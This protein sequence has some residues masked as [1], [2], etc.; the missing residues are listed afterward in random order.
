M[1]RY[2]KQHDFYVAIVTL[3]ANT[4]LI[5]A[6]HA[7]PVAGTAIQP[8]EILVF[9]SNFNL[10]GTPVSAS[11]GVVF[12]QQL[13]LRPISRTAELLEFVPGLIATQHSGEGKAN[14]YFVRGFNLDHGTDFAIRLDR[15][16]VNMPSHGH[17]Q[18]Y[19]DINFIIPELVNRMTYRKGPYYASGGDF[20]TAGE[21]QFSY[22]DKLEQGQTH[23]TLGENAFQRF[24]AGQSL[25]IGGGALTLA[26]A[27]SQYNGPWQLDQDL[28]KRKLVAKFHQSVDSGAWSITAMHYN[29]D[30]T[31]TDQIPLRAVESG[32]L[33]RWG[34]IDPTAG[35]DSRRNSL[36]FDLQQ[37]LSD[38]TDWRFNA[39]GID[40]A[41]DLYSNFTYFANNPVNGDQFQQTD[42]RRIAGFDSEYRRELN[43][44]IPTEIRAG[45][46]H[47]YDDIHVGLHLTQAR[48]RYDSVRND[49]VEQ[50]LSSSYV[51]A[52]QQWS[53]RI[54]TESSLR[55][56]HYRFEVSDLLGR[57]SGR[58][59][60]TLFSPKFNLVYAPTAGVETFFSAG[61]GFHSNDARGATI[62]VDPVTGLA[63][64]PVDPMAD[65]RSVELGLR[66]SVIPKTQLA[67]T[68]FSMRLSSEL[69]Y[70]GDAGSTEASDASQREGLEINAIYT[71]NSWLL[72]DADASVT[73]ARIRGVGAENRIPN[74][75]RN[76]A[77]LGM[78]IDDLNNWSGG[79]RVRYLG[80]AP[81]IE[82]ASVFSQSTLLMN[83]E[84]S[85]AFTP[86]LSVAVSLLNLLDSD[87]ND[88]TYFYE[89]QLAKESAPVEDIHFHPVEPRSVRVS[90]NAR[91]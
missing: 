66:T 46:Q 76:T 74:A 84:L 50:S 1:M 19:A 70:V 89:S 33:S 56:D 40:Y 24:F 58:G 12:E 10:R 17:G 22:A 57:N 4:V 31:S 86:T 83:A 65:A 78:I 11:E 88:I 61:R 28:D 49:D 39:Y 54:R 45:V 72:F 68:A 21:A 30:W 52:E 9:G 64:D 44:S 41:L 27:L 75:V 73:N 62:Q 20:A 82:D 48:Q 60:D 87:D 38:R 42:S 15:M 67:V 13:Q 6:V 14:Q 63:T 32:S 79:L 53:E 18:G 8:Q 85:Y 5:T 36:S 3:A 37:T 51:A 91:F 25:E 23:I 35:G 47:R 2:L 77:S 16:P 43:T 71:P 69:V 55:V 7:Q 80:S 29:N 90:V 59:N 26:G 81:L 34:N